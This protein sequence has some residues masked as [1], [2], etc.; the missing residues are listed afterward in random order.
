MDELCEVV[1]EL[2]F[3][4]SIVLG[5]QAGIDLDSHSRDTRVLSILLMLRDLH[6]DK[7]ERLGSSVPHMHVI[8]ENQEDSTSTLALP[9]KTEQH[10]SV[11][12]DFINSQAISARVLVQTLA[13]PHISKA[14]AEIFTEEEGKATIAFEAC[15]GLIPI[16]TPI[17]FATVREFVLDAAEKSRPIVIGVSVSP[18]HGASV[19]PIVL[20]S[21]DFTMSYGAGDRLIMIKL[22]ESNN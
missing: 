2:D 15:E 22:Y 4:T 10:N 18:K 13:Y 16:D 1:M 3:H 11:E 19:G 9:P 6:S 21:D 5:T 14:V 7:V 8:G 20:P 12:P 17:D